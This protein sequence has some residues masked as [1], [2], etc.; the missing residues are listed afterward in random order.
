VA[1]TDNLIAYYKLDE[2]SGNASDSAGSGIT[3]VNNGSAT[4]SAGKINNGS[5]FPAAGMFTLGSESSFDFESNNAFSISFWVKYTDNTVEFQLISKLMSVE[6]YTGWEIYV[7]QGAIGLWLLKN[8]YQPTRCRVNTVAAYNNGNWRHVVV[9]HDGT[10][11]GSGVSFYVDG[12]VVAKTIISDS[13]DGNSILNNVSVYFAGRQGTPTGQV[14]FS[15]DEIAIYNRLLSASE[16][17]SLWNSGNGLS[18]PFASFNTAWANKVSTA[19]SFF[20]RV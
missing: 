17:T 15:M 18:Y 14:T 6:P 20:E 9:T 19:I 16:V 8:Y 13:L 11:V 5:N 7:Q 1:L 3:A 10:H 2:S 12:S 4:F